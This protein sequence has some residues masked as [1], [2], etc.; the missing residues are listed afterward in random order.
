MEYLYSISSLFPEDF[1]YWYTCY[2]EMLQ[3][4]QNIIMIYLKLRGLMI[5]A[6]IGS[7]M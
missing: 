3:M 2:D 4:N 5:K 7:T 1:E 6:T